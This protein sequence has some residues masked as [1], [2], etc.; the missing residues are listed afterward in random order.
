MKIPCSAF[1]SL[2]ELKS[3]FITTPSATPAVRVL[4]ELFQFCEM[5]ALDTY[6]VS[7]DVTTDAL[8]LFYS[9]G[10]RQLVRRCEAALLAITKDYGW[11]DAEL[12]DQAITNCVKYVLRV[13]RAL[14]ILT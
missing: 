2:K 1:Q 12:I 4:G 6:V 14:S 10:V 13:H 3:Q 9:P 7:F 8:R 5:P 11:L